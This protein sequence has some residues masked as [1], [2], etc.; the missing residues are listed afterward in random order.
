MT[1]AL[2]H[3]LL[4]Q[5]DRDPSPIS[6]AAQAANAQRIRP[7]RQGGARGGPHE[8]RR[9]HA[10]RIVVGGPMPY[11]QITEYHEAVQH[12]ALAFVDPELKQGAVAENNLGLPLV[13]SGGFALTYA[14]TTARKKVRRA[15]LPSGD[16]C[17]PAEI[18]CDREEAALADQ[19]ILCRFRFPASGHQRPRSRPFRSCGW[20]GS[21]AIPLGIWLDKHF[22]DPRGARKGSC[23]FRRHRALSR[24]ERDCTRRHPER[25]R[26]GRRTAASS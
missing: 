14:V 12:P 25:Q 2:G 9:H 8:A 15:L 5:R 3:W 16:P 7:L 13:M 23:R 4:S 10:D 22:D 20:T 18:R 6:V 17:D 24:A 26:H 11:P 1:D 21:R 19:R